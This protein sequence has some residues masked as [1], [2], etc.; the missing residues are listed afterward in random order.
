[1][2]DDDYKPAFNLTT[3]T[4]SS[5]VYDSEF[6]D[7]NGLR[8]HAWLKTVLNTARGY[9]GDSETENDP[10]EALG[11]VSDTDSGLSK[12]VSAHASIYVPQGITA[13]NITDG[14]KYSDKPQ[15]WDA[16]IRSSK[17][18]IVLVDEYT[19]PAPGTPSVEEI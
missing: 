7:D 1:M 15:R 4:N 5:R 3:S 9:T 19:I 18:G 2:V 11:I 13:V 16:K 17:D 10:H 12:D 6:N 14:K 8:A